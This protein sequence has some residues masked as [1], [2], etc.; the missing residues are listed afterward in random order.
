[1]A[2]LDWLKP[3]PALA[4]V[5]EAIQAALPSVWEQTGDDWYTC[6]PPPGYDPE[7]AIVEAIRTFDPGAI[8]IWRLQTWK[9]PGRRL[10]VQVVHVGIARYSAV[11]TFERRHLQVQMPAEPEHPVPNLL[12]TFFEGP[13]VGPN[14]PAAYDPLD[15]AAVARA[16]EKVGRLN[17]EEFDRRI[18]ARKTREA[19]IREAWQ[20]E[21]DYI[22]QDVE[23]RILRT[24]DEKVGDYDWEQLKHLYRV[25]LRK[26]K[27]RKPFVHLRGVA[28]PGHPD[29]GSHPAKGA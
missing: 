7:P 16:R 26:A 25:G 24:L 11:P 20:E 9:A 27:G 4:E 21:L 23:P 28:L 5:Q 22:K 14:G 18:E 29:A 3:D 10:P 8:I 19:L 2:Y 6:V 13:P 15:W 17:V 12:D 1:M